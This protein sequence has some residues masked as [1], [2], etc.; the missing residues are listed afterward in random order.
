MISTRQGAAI[1]VMAA[2]GVLGMS[3]AGLA[4]AKDGPPGQGPCSHGNSG[5]ECKPDPQPDH[6]EECDEHGPNEG[7]VNE[8]HCAVDPTETTETT[9][10]TTT[11]TTG[12]TPSVSP[13]VDTTTTPDLF[14][15]PG[16]S[17]GTAGE[18]GEPGNDNCATITAGGATT[19]TPTTTPDVE[20]PPSMPSALTPPLG[21]HPTTQAARH[22]VI[23]ANLVAAR[24]KHDGA[25]QAKGIHVLPFT[26]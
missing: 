1:V 21:Q 3:S 26:P 17:P 20:T 22:G 18:D 15:C 19:G 9:V 2:I 16:G 5:K 24:A 8:D 14:R 6:G 12:T 11:G 7:G 23:G 13:T 4:T 10:D 25:A